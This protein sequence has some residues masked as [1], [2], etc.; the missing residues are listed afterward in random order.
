MTAPT[1]ASGEAYDAYVGRWSSIF[2]GE[3]LTWVGM[4]GG[5]RWLD[6]G[7]GTGGLSETVVRARDAAHV[8]AR[9][10]VGS[11]RLDGT[12]SALG[13]ASA[14]DGARCSSCGTSGTRPLH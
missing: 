14:L 10:S 8:Y 2:P 11:V 3:F 12:P 13:H 4:S 1:W 5:G 9:G 7:G 6:V